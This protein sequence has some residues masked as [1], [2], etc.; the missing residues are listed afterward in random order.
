MI[1]LILSILRAHTCLHVCKMKN[2]LRRAHAAYTCSVKFEL[3]CTIT[4]RQIARY[5][6]AIAIRSCM[7]ITIALYHGYVILTENSTPLL[8]DLYQYIT[9][10]YASDWKV[11][12]TLL[13]IPTG[14]LK[15]IEAGYPTNIKWCCNQMMEKWLEMD[16][17]ASWGKLF[18]VIES[19]AVSAAFDKG[20]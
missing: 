19:P 14:E 7:T 2:M 15:I 18:G 3:S 9:P 13:D 20:R 16:S 6:I 5:Y 4:I 11:I 1:G 10:R 17:T 12:G 8:K